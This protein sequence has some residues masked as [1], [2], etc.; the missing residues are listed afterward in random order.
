VNMKI[1][2]EKQQLKTKNTTQIS[3]CAP[4]MRIKQKSKVEENVNTETEASN[5]YYC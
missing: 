3:G 2:Q 5:F 4:T 1:A